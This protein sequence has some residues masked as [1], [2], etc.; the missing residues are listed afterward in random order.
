MTDLEQLKSA[1]DT[2][3]G[4]PLGDTLNKVCQDLDRLEQQN[5]ELVRQVQDLQDLVVSK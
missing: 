3:R 2:F 1:A 4:T 5:Q